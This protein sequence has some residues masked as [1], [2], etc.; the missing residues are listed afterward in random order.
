MVNL[1]ARF[2]S[3]TRLITT[4]KLFLKKEDQ[5][6]HFKNFQK[7]IIFPNYGKK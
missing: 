1:S 6:G 2:T 7:E 3:N 5:I 4:Q